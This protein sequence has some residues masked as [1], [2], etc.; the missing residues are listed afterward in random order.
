MG[1]VEELN[2]NIIDLDLDLE[3][4]VLRES[5]G[6]PTVVRVHGKVIKIQHPSLWSTTAMKAV[7]NADWVAWAQEVIEDP[8]EY[9][10]FEE[11]NLLN[12][13]MQAIFKRCGQDA[14]SDLGKS[15]RLASSSNGT[16]KT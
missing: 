7:N 8:D 16:R 11:C 9:R 15:K 12:F 14:G 2:G 4:A 5:V 3:D 6:K 13:Q 10:H 1:E